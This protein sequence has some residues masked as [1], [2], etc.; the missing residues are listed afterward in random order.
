MVKPWGPFQTFAWARGGVRTFGW[1]LGS[2]VGPG[3]T[4]RDTR[5]ALRRPWDAGEGFFLWVPVLG[6]FKRESTLLGDLKGKASLKTN[7]YGCGG[8]V[9]ALASRLHWSNESVRKLICGVDKGR[10]QFSCVSL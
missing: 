5:R 2:G 10:N 9:L 1:H 7:L 3:P 6:C 8:H 4:F